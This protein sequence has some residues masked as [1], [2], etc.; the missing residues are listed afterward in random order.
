MYVITDDLSQ[1]LSSVLYQALYWFLKYTRWV[2]E[3]ALW[4]SGRQAITMGLEASVELEV[5]VEVEVSVGSEFNKRKKFI[6]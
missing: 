1:T 6:S 4:A 2:S 5:P 3:S